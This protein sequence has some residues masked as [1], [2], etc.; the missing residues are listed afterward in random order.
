ME[1]P[2]KKLKSGFEMAEYG[3][4]TWQMGGRTEHDQNN[5]DQADIAGIHAAIDHGVTCLDTAEI[6]ASGYSETLL[7]RA[8]EGYDRTKLFLSSKVSAPHMRHDDVLAAC[9]ASL[10]RVGT[11]YFDLY[12]LHRHAPEVPLKETMSALDKLVADGRVRNIGV[13]NFNVESLKEAQGYTVNPIVYNQVHYNLVMRECEHAGLL[14]YCQ[15]ND[16]ILAAWRPVEKGALIESQS[17]VL[18][19]MCKKYEKTPAQIALNW[20]ISQDNVVTLSKTRHVEHLEENL[21]AL[22]WKMEP[23]DIE[24]LRS[25]YP[26]QQ[27]VSPTVPLG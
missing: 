16:I 8:I 1:I 27:F 18:A 13:C 10:K 5:D 19:E 2:T 21:G 7:G 22:G 17:P 26:S 24:R 25:E 20:L 6:Y 12:L 14:E 15:Q 23:D 4:G 3:F 9:E 11:D